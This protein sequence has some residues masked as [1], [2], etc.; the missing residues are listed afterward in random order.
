MYFLLEIIPGLPCPWV[1]FPEMAYR[2]E[3][4]VIK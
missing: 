2:W 4:K 3:E 1:F